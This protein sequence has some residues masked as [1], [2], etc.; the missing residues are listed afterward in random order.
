MYIGY[1]IQLRRRKSDG[2][3]NARFMNLNDTLPI[4]IRLR[5]LAS[6][7]VPDI[8]RIG[9]ILKLVDHPV[10]ARIRKERRTEYNPN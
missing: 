7:T 10:L 5:S 6:N 3:V 2:L 9:L 1:S 4:V 8:L